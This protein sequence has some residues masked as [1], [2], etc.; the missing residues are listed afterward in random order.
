MDLLLL[1][2]AHVLLDGTSNSAV[3]VEVLADGTVLVEGSANL[4]SGTTDSTVGC[5]ND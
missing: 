2:V 3:G 1:A 5:R 4:L